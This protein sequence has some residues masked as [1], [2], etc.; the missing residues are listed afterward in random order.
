MKPWTENSHSSFHW[1]GV[2][3]LVLFMVNSSADN[4]QLPPAADVK[5]CLVQWMTSHQ[6]LTLNVSLS[7]LPHS[8]APWQH[9]GGR[10]PLSGL[11]LVS[12]DLVVRISQFNRKLCIVAVCLALVYHSCTSCLTKVKPDS[13]L[14]DVLSLMHH[15]T[16]DLARLPPHCSICLSDDVLSHHTPSPCSHTA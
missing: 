9:I 13:C 4:L 11:W 10:I 3:C 16:L 14:S 1:S 6:W 15:G 5:G 8:A 2:Q 12:A 7:S